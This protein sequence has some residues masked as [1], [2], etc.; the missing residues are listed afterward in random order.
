MN[1][2]S[3]QK[4]RVLIPDAVRRVVLI[5][6]GYRCAVP[7]CRAILALDLHHI[8]EVAEGGKNVESNLLAL[9]PTC[10][11]L[12]TRGTITKDAIN[13]WKIT[14]ITLNQAFD[15]DSIDNLLFLNQL[16]R[17]SLGISG[18]GV[19]KFSHLISSGFAEYKIL[20][21]NGPIILYE[22]Y[23]TNRGQNVIAAWVSGNRN[24]FQEALSS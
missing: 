9:C 20:I 19:L 14:L 6:S 23:L 13:A 11:A 15:R 18:D 10:H 8:V 7:T 3:L 12:Y 1:T 2:D 24:D 21:Q 16:Q 5:E 22:V 4:R 17:N